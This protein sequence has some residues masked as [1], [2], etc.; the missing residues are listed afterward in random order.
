[1]GHNRT[2][3]KNYVI[4]VPMWLKSKFRTSIENTNT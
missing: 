3:Q 4:D 1:M 2:D